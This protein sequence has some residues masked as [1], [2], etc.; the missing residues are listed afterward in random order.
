[1]FDGR[2]KGESKGRGLDL[3]F[4]FF[5][6][7]TRWNCKQKCMCICIYFFVNVTGIHLFFSWIFFKIVNIDKIFEPSNPFKEISCLDNF[8]ITSIYNSKCQTN[9]VQDK[10]SNIIVKIY[11]ISFNK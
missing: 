1:M 4:L 3:F 6:E 10:S 5:L 11:S 9:K 7:I 2:G 8:P